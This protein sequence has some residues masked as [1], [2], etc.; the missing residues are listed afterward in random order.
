MSLSKTISVEPAKITLAEKKNKEL[1]S[2]LLRI[3]I[4]KRENE[5]NNKFN[6]LDLVFPTQSA[7]NDIFRKYAVP[8]R[9][10]F[11][12]LL[13]VAGLTSLN[14]AFSPWL[15]SVGILEIIFGSFLALG[16][17]SRPIMALS[18]IMFLALGIT[19][20][21]IGQIDVTPFAMMFGSLIFF[22]QGGGKYSCDTLIRKSIKRY[23][24]NRRIKI[25]KESLSYKA[26]SILT[27]NI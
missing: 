27:K 16:L 10:I 17:L 7:A 20:L 4:L 1:A 18:S 19:S 6:L 26:F 5:Y 14:H 21:R 9:T 3:S 24:V 11:S 2:E 22:L 8:A 13:I 25:K 12:A 23:L 15:N